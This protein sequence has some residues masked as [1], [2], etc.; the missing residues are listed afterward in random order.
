MSFNPP[1][2]PAADQTYQYGNIIWRFDGTAGVWNIVDGSLVGEQGPPGPAGPQGPQGEKGNTGSPAT[3]D[4]ASIIVS[5]GFITARLGAVGTTGV[6]GVSNRFSVV[7][8]IAYP[9][10]ASNGASGIASFDSVYFDV[11]STGHV[12]IKGDLGVGG[13]TGDTVLGGVAIG[14][15]SEG[16]NVKRI[17]NIG[18][19]SFNGLTGAVTLTGDGGAVFGRGNNIIGARLADT[20]TTGV[21]SFSSSFF[22]VNGSGVVSLASPYSVV[23]VTGIGF[24]NDVGLTGK[25]NLTAADA[26]MTITRN[27]NT[28]SFASNAVGGAAAGITASPQQVLFSSG[29]GGTGSNNFVFNGLAATFGGANTQF[30]ITG[31]T[32][33]IGNN[34]VVR[35]GIYYDAAESA[36]YYPFENSPVLIKASDGSVQRIGINP[37]GTYVVGFDDGTEGNWTNAIGVAESVVV[38]LQSSS[39][40]TGAFGGG[41]LT[42]SPPPV[43]GGLTGGV[44]VFT[45]MRIRH[46]SGAIKM[47]FPIA[48]SMTG[49]NYSIGT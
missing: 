38:I 35:G 19:T 21:A 13:V 32:F 18:V 33:T 25:I 10:P 43:L 2:F 9:L 42:P 45:L 26:S 23:G 48:R 12:S 49:P 41:I 24:G 22:S 16:G 17:N 46:S 44:D 7:N 11:T 4:D 29:N 47:A 14:V 39:G 6:L 5:N 34:T 28:I 37:S 30:T 20:S 15:A 40:K 31:P 8:G 1:Q 36:P 27:G 3:G